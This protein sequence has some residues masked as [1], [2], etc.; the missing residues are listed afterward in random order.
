MLHC[1][2]P[3]PSHHTNSEGTTNEQNSRNEA[4]TPTRPITAADM[5]IQPPVL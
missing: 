5:F 4:E 1:T 2:Q 3:V